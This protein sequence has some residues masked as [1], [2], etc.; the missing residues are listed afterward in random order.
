LKRGDDRGF[1][2][3]ELIVVVVILGILLGI[4]AFSYRSMNDRYAVEKQMKEMY[5]D[6]MSA[7][8][9]AMQRNR[10]HFVLFTTTQYTVYEDTTPTP[11]GN[12]TLETA[13]DAKFMQKSL[14]SR[15]AVTFPAAWGSALT[16]LRFTSRGMLDTAQ[17][18]TGTVRVVEELNGEYDCLAIS[19][20]RN[21]LGKWDATSSSCKAK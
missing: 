12:G 1:T 5:V 14:Y 10:V 18:S 19:E 8:I 6:L 16:A 13:S 3:V 17:T 20:I 21:T 2:L 4:A 7:R 9:R 15:Y 11:D